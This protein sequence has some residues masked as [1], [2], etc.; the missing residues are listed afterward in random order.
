[1]KNIKF[2][3]LALVAVCS[4]LVAVAPAQTMRHDHMDA[5]AARMDIKRLKMDR[6]VA[7]RTHNWGKVAQDDRLLAADRHFIKMDKRGGG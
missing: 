2:G 4:A 7:M 3:F 1:M 6:K 5:R